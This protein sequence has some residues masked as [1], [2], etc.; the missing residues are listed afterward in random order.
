MLLQHG[1]LP[2]L[3]QANGAVGAGEEV[4]VGHHGAGAAVVFGSWT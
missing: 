4:V 1:F 2:G 3:E